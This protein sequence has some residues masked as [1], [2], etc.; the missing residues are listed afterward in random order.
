MSENAFLKKAKALSLPSS[1]AEGAS[2]KQEGGAESFGAGGG[3]QK[4]LLDL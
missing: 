1:K 4:D 2:T 3:E